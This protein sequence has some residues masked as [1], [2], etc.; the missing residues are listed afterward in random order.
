[1][2]TTKKKRL[3]IK[4]YWKILRFGMK[5]R[6]KLKK[7]RKEKEEKEEKEAKEMGNDEVKP[8]I[9]TTEFWIS[10]IGGAVALW[11]QIQ[12]KVSEPWGLVVATVLGAVYT[13][14]R[15]IT[16]KQ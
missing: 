12:D 13:I 4:D 9:K 3:G 2:A 6:G 5:I 1:M 16:K 15:A 7:R 14:S 10:I 8:G 11:A